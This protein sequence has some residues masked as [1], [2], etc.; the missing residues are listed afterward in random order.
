LI[1]KDSRTAAELQ[2]ALE[3]L[4]SDASHP[5]L[6]THKLKGDLEGCWACTAGYDLRIVF[7]FVQHEGAEAI[8]LES[9]GT[10]EEVY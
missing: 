8:L 10:H 2:E 6:R 4:A 5:R 3:G 7:R 9:V 1:K